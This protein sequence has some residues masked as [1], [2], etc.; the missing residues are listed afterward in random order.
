MGQVP[1]GLDNAVLA[2]FGALL[3]R[4]PAPNTAKWTSAVMAGVPTGLATV[5]AV[6]F[7]DRHL[8]EVSIRRA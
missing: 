8:Y 2:Q 4:C 7:H 6:R 1:I 5:V 3:T